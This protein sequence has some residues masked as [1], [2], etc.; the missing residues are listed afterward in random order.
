MSN[1]FLNTKWLATN[2]TAKQLDELVVAQREQQDAQMFSNTDTPI[3]STAKK[4][5]ESYEMSL[6][7]FSICFQAKYY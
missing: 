7:L 5:D 6:M 2:P 3:N 1:M 4:L